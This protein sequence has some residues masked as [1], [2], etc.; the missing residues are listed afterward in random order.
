VER[1]I[2]QSRETI[3]VVP[4]YNEAQRLNLPEFQAFATE[5]PE[6]QF[7]FVND[8]STDDTAA[9]LQEFH[10]SRP[11][12]FLVHTLPQNRGKAE[13][14]RQGILHALKLSSS[15]VGFWDADLSTPLDEV[16]GMLAIFHSR[17]HIEMVF[18]ARVNLLGRQV[19]RKL[20]RH[21]LGRVFATLIARSLGLGIYDTQCGAKLFL[22]ND[23]LVELF[24]EPFIS[25]W[26][27]DVEI[28]ARSIQQRRIKNL[29]PINQII[30]EQPLKKWSDIAGSKIRF[31]DF[32]LVYGDFFRIYNRYLRRRR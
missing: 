17:P 8:G 16:E 18:G 19:R 10:E 15:Y 28:I 26:I 27:F 32:F 25:K 24:Q 12:A 2:G 21:Y 6:I 29:T 11:E 7:L 9:I 5:N 3:L 22:V 13:A 20:H 23:N 14:V 1:N 30:Y 4:C 31:R